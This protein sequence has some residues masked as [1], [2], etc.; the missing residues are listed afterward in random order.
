M[1]VI[2]DARWAGDGE[3][4]RDGAEHGGPESKRRQT[5]DDHATIPETDGNMEGPI[6]RVVR[7]GPGEG[8]WERGF[9]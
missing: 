7:S 8:T 1:G 6:R 2:G 9:R 5:W 3:G 4:E